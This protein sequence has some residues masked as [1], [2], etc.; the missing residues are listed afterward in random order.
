M[1]IDYTELFTSLGKL[2]KY[3]NTFATTSQALPAAVAAIEV[4]FQAEDKLDVITGLNPGNLNAW[5]SEYTG[6][7]NS[8]AAMARKRFNEPD[9]ADELGSPSTDLTAIMPL[10]IEQMIADTDSVNASVAAI[11]SVTPNGSNVGTM[12]ILSTLLLDRVTSPGG[13]QGI[14]YPATHSYGNVTSELPVA[15]TMTWRVIADSYANGASEGGETLSWTG[16]VPDAAN[17]TAPSEGSGT[18]GTFQ[19]IH[20]ST[21]KYLLNAD[22]ETWS[23]TNTPDSWTIDAGAV[24]TNIVQSSSSNKTHGTYGCKLLGSGAASIQISQAFTT[25]KIK[26]G[27]RYCV[28]FW[29]KADS[30]I[31]AGTFT[32]QFEGT[33]YSAG[34]AEKVSIAFGAMPTAWTLKHFFVL[35]P[36]TVPSDFKLV[37]KWTGTPTTAK[38]TYLDDFGMGEVNY[39]GGLGVVAVRGDTPAVRDDRWTSAITNTEGVIQKFFRRV[40]GYQLP[41]DNTASE[42]IADSL[43]T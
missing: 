21:S 38:A 22:F 19:A 35:M 15:E 4:A 32:V 9:L 30:A 17:G 6:R 43:A 39:G 28:T 34:A 36:N 41:S 13:R 16:D 2:I 20:A 26:P 23:V 18:I 3:F 11:G 24:T 25:A 12:T 27:K 42:T 5:T 37:V 33:G 8:L 31:L 10:F 40:F 29:M 1:A 7:R 14:T